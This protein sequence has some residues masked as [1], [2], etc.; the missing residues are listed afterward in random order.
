[1][2]LIH[3]TLLLV[4]FFVLLVLELFLP[5]GGLLGIAA[6]AALVAA[7]VTGFLHSLVAGS[8]TLV[9]TAVLVPIFVSIGLRVWPRTPIGRRIL[10]LDTVAN[11]ARETDSRTLREV[12]IGKI[13]VTKTNL[14]PSGL[15]EIEGVRMDAISIGVAIDKGQPIEVVDISSGK[16]RVRPY[17][18]TAGDG[19]IATSLETPIESL[20]ID[21]WQ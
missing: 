14:L 1:M 20:G 7:I 13:G 17:L 3:T 10:T 16:I 15:V 2:T 12:I 8:A 4:L 9:I 19:P 21:D 6:A 5:S 18:A 11:E